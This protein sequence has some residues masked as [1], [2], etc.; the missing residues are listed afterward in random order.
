MS[1]WARVATAFGDAREL[2]FMDAARW[3][4]PEQVVDVSVING[5][6]LRRLLFRHPA[7]RAMFWYRLGGALMSLG[8]RGAAG[9]V[10]RR[11][12]R[13]YGLE[14]QVGK[15]VKGGLYIAHPVGCVIVAE[16]IGENVT[17]IS[18]VTFGTRGEASWPTV[19]D[20]CF[21]GVGAR[22]LGSITIGD[23]ARIG[24][25]AVVLSDVPPAS[26]AV[27]IPAQVVGAGATVA[28]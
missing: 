25:N 20:R 16:S 3:V 21:F 2:F 13:L 4:V 23:D 26:T 18:Q 22:V 17:I 27:G 11:L 9:W 8:V 5:R 24:A 12:M 19:G 28:V 14:I 15:P 10:Q 6:V 7:L 1:R